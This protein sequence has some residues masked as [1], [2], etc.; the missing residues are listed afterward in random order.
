VGGGGRP[1]LDVRHHPGRGRAMSTV[2]AIVVIAWIVI[3]AFNGWE[4]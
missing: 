1:S 2:I 3:L 4:F